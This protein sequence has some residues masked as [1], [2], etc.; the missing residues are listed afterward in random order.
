MQVLLKP[1]LTIRG[2]KMNANVERYL[3][4]ANGKWFVSHYLNMHGYWVIKGEGDE[5]GRLAPDLGIVHGERD[6]V[7]AYAVN[8]AQF[9][10]YGRGGSITKIFVKEVNSETIRQKEKLEREINELTDK[11]KVIKERLDML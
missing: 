8:L 11:L 9:W 10:S 4:T 2:D 1:C 3:K 7:L 5:D 6:H